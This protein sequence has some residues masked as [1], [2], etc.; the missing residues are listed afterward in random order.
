AVARGIGAHASGQGGEPGHVV[1]DLPRIDANSGFDWALAVTERSVGQA[2]ELLARR[3]RS[4]RH[5]H[6]SAEPPPRRHN[7]GADEEEETEWE[8]HRRLGQVSQPTYPR[9]P[10]LAP[11]HGAS[12]LDKPAKFGHASA[13][14]RANPVAMVSQSR[15]RSEP[16]VSR[17]YPVHPPHVFAFS[18]E[19]GVIAWRCPRRPRQPARL[20]PERRAEG[21]GPT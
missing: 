1:L 13:R 16:S 19:T 14:R 15:C 4:G 6:R 10:W 9:R 7:R 21:P 20:C 5:R 8:T 18:A 17:S 2:I 11:P 3:E 12:L